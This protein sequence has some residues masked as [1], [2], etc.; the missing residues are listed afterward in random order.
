MGHLQPVETSRRSLETDPYQTLHLIPSAPHDLIVEVYWHLVHHFQEAAREDVSLRPRLDELNQAYAQLVDPD[1]RAEPAADLADWHGLLDQP[2]TTPPRTDSRFGRLWKR[3]VTRRPRPVSPWEILHLHP[4][5][6]ADVVE[7]AYSFWRL[8]LRSQLGKSAAPELEKLH[9]ARQTLRSRRSEASAEACCEADP[10]TAMGET[11][12]AELVCRPAGE[13][14]AN[15][16][17]VDAEATSNGSVGR[18]AR[19]GVSRRAAFSRWVAAT[20]G[21]VWERLR[22][23]SKSRAS[24]P[25]PWFPVGASEATREDVD[26]SR[27]LPGPAPHSNGADRATASAASNEEPPDQQ[28]AEPAEHVVEI[29]PDEA[30]EASDQPP[31]ELPLGSPPASETIPGVKSSQVAQPSQASA[32][33]VAE[34]GLAKGVRAAIGPDPVSIGTDP[35]CDLILTE[36]IA[37]GKYVAARIWRQEDRFMF[38]GIGSTPTVLVNGQALVWALLEDGDKLEIGDD[39]FR[40]QRTVPETEKVRTEAEQS[41]LELTRDAGSQHY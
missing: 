38:H 16:E 9:E 37:D 4:E 31:A 41:D 26:A 40:F 13:P 32:H 17:A 10:E 12:A 19:N 2:A 34:S 18:Q 6:P 3:P 1:A 33:L 21:A 23:S 14:A 36:A 29:R 8:S 27:N 39:V 7:L 15:T 30:R 11:M 25:T 28:L 5:A 20:G 22:G 35:T 24:D